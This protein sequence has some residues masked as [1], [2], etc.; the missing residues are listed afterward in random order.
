MVDGEGHKERVKAGEHGGII[1][2]SWTKM[3]KTRPA[4]TVLRR[5]VCKGERWRTESN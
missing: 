3:E 2:N 1:S 5:R 4:E